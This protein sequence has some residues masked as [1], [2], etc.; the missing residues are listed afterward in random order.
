MPIKIPNA[1][2]AAQTLEK[3]N[4]FVMTE[5]RAQMQ[6]IRP[7]KIVILN[8]MPTKIDT[9]T[10]LLRLLSNSPLQVE[11][12]LLQTASYTPKNTPMEH[13]LNFYKTFDDIK[14]NR[15]D[16]MIITGAPIEHLAFED[17]DY[18]PEL[19]EI[20]TW[21]R[22]NIY[23]TLHICWGAQAALYYHYKV[24][25]YPLSQKLT[26]VFR[27]RPLDTNHPLLKGFDECFYMP[28]SRFT[29]IR[30]EDVMAVDSLSILAVSEAAE[31]V[32]LSNATGRRVFIT[33]HCEYD[34]DTLKGEYLRD[35]QRGISP[36]PF[37]QNYFPQNDPEGIPLFTW[38]S[39][40]NLLFSN[41]L[42]YFVYQ[43]TPFDLS[44]LN[45]IP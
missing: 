32:I 40:A 18:W 10:Q 30:T 43:Q 19:C 13:L 3:E 25:K 37:P 21:S 16:G 4:I 26:G 38:S 24:K 44:S 17:V 7:L 20:M 31:P 15:Y 8:L 6:D 33:G 35:V 23:S 5:H 36:I 29:E 42:N 22:K 9:E 1:L 27:H 2:P 41:W 45:L 12:D 34:R 39:H 11:I 28:H 14:K